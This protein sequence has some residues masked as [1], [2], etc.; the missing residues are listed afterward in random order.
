MSTILEYPTEDWLAPSEILAYSDYWNDE[1]V[2]RSKAWW[3]ADGDMQPM[4]AHLVRTG[5]RAQFDAVASF[6]ARIGRPITGVG[7]DLGAGTLWA[8]P[9]LLRVGASRI[10]S[11]EYSQHRLLKLGPIV[12]AHYGVRPDQA[13]LVRGDFSRLRLDAASMDFV[14]LAEAFH[15]A[16]SPMQLLAEIRRVLKPDGVVLIIGEHD[17]DLRPLDYFK[18]PI[19]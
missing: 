15:H 3:V 5:L 13:V 19:K 11:V 2:E 4:E 16:D 8:T 9:L 18:Q 14:F 17:C 10:Y 1:D 7:C 12:L 6:A